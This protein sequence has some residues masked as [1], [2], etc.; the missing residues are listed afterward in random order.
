M[1][2]NLFVCGSVFVALLAIAHHDGRYGLVA[3]DQD[4]IPLGAFLY[5]AIKA[6]YGANTYGRPA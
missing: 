2:T 5:Y 4:P 3:D 1:L 6:G